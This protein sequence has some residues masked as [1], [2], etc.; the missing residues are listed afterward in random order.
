MLTHTGCHG[1]LAHSFK[2]ASNIR[3]PLAG[4]YLLFESITSH[5]DILSEDKIDY[6][7]EGKMGEGKGGKRGWNG[8]KCLG[9]D[10]E[11]QPPTPPQGGYTD[12]L[13]YHTLPSIVWNGKT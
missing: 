6:T 1:V 13:S 4:K 7:L 2:G 11:A 3:N 12:Y 10:R 9:A 8:E 5:S